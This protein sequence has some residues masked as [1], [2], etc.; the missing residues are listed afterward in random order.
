MQISIDALINYAAANYPDLVS[1][2]N[3]TGLVRRAKVKRRQIEVNGTHQ[4]VDYG[5]VIAEVPSFVARSLQRPHDERDLLVLIHI[6]REVADEAYQSLT[7]LIVS[8]NGAS[9]IVPP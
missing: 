1:I 4:V 2:V 9:L 3:F 6:P 5:Q 8:S 7:S